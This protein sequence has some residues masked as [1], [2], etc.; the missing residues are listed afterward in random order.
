MFSLQVS[1]GLADLVK[2]YKDDLEKLTN[3]E[4]L[5]HKIEAI[6]QEQRRKEGTA[7]IGSDG[8]TLAPVKESTIRRGRGGDGPPLAPR[9]ESSRSISNFSVAVTADTDGSILITGYWPGIEDWI[10][11]H[12]VDTANR[13]AR[14]IGGISPE[15]DGLIWEEVGNF[16]EE[17]WAS[18]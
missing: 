13:V 5:A 2:Q 7:G 14:N 16:V 6:L 10:E 15:T 3:L 8:Q 12:F 17:G 1:G 4:D 18:L 11:T 9:G